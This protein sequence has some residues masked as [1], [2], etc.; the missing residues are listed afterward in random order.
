MQDTKL[1]QADVD[2]VL[3]LIASAKTAGIT[4]LSYRGVQVKFSR[5]A[6]GVTQT[7]RVS[8]AKWNTTLPGA[9]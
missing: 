1:D 4:E 9:E 7:A 2:F 3:R 6:D 5:T 8:G